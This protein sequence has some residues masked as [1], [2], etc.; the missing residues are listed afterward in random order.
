[1]AKGVKSLNELRDS[2]ILFE[3][4]L[5]PF[6]YAIVLI[7][8]IALLGVVV[9]STKAPK[10]Y[11]VVSTGTVSNSEANYVMPAYS[12][13]ILNSYMQ[14][15]AVVEEGEELFTIASTDY[16]LQVEQLSATRAVYETKIAQFEKLVES[17]QDDTNYF[18]ASSAEDAL[19]Y[20]TYEA[21]KAQIVQNTVD[22]SSYK[23]YGYSDEQIKVELEKNSAKISEIYHAAIQSAENNI[24]ESQ[25][26]IAS[27]DAQ[28]SALKSGQEKYVVTAPAS[29]TIHMLEDYKDGMVVQAGSAVATITP[30]N[31]GALI[32]AYISSA[33]VSRI[34][35]GDSVEMEVTGLMQSVYGTISGTV[36]QISSDATTQ[37]GS[38]GSSQLVFKVLIHPDM[39]YVISNNGDKVDLTNGMTVET[40]IQYKGITYFDYVMQKL[41]VK[42]G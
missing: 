9:W 2:R 30:D 33:E 10:I 17:I 31:D 22:V 1:M 8:L 39:L 11:V 21:Y 25:T 35:E 23:D 5:P 26:Q 28:L 34:H 40:R 4:N 36:T 6:G 20:S 29:G 7:V 37:E 24:A 13:T 38:D 27:I 19:Y 14:E 12:G 32:E 16:D 42:A 41:G 18:S 3:K 15:G